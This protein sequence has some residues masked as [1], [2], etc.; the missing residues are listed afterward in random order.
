M[1]ILGHSDSMLKIMSMIYDYASV[2]EEYFL[3][4]RVASVLRMAQVDS[5]LEMLQRPLHWE[6]IVHILVSID[7]IVL[8][9]NLEEDFIIEELEGV[10]KQ[11]WL[12]T[13]YYAP[14][15]DVALA[16]YRTFFNALNFKSLL[17]DSDLRD[18]TFIYAFYNK[19]ATDIVQLFIFGLISDMMNVSMIPLQINDTYYLGLP[20]TQEDNPL[21]L[22]LEF[23][24]GNVYMDKVMEA[25]D[26]SNIEYTKIAPS[27]THSTALIRKYVES[28]L[29]SID[30]EELSLILALEKVLQSL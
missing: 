9:R 10:R 17:P 22:L 24:D 8:L 29:Q 12:N 23:P 25:F 7:E 4:D 28:L 15:R 21:M 20:R 2:R 11:L 16:I 27:V 30:K 1:G 13:H 14:K 19:R 6:N 5:I 26:Y 18:H 3:T